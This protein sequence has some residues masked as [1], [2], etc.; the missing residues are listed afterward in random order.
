VTAFVVLVLV[1]SVL[2]AVSWVRAQARHLDSEPEV[3]AFLAARAATSG[4]VRD[5]RPIR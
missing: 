4:G 3:A 1:C 2:A 5:V